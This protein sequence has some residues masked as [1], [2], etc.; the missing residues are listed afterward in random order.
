MEY[1]T[2]QSWKKIKMSEIK[3]FKNTIYD[4]LIDS[5]KNIELKQTYINNK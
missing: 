5:T 1:I 4:S 3:K 2:L